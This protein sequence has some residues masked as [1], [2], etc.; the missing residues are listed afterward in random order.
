MVFY[1]SGSKE[2]HPEYF[3][4]CK[5]RVFWDTVNPLNRHPCFAAL[6]DGFAGKVQK[7]TFVT[8]TMYF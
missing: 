7:H 6:A 3:K 2:R 4:I 1:L 5:I 8:S